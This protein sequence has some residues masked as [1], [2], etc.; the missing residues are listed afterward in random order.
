M[1]FGNWNDPGL[2]RR[3]NCLHPGIGAPHRDSHIGW[4]RS[5]ALVTGAEYG[6]NSV[7]TAQ[8]RT[9]RSGVALVARLGDVVEIIASASAAADCRRSWPLFRS[10]CARTCQQSSTQYSIVQA[11]AKIGRE[12]AVSDQRTDT[13]AALRTVLGPCPGRDG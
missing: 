4:M 7:E 10:W 1:Q 8:C 13:Q 12:V 3:V 9:T 5:Y 2:T 6:V 11:H